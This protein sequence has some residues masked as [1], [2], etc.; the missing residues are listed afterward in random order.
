MTVNDYYI[1]SGFSFRSVYVFSINS[2][3]L[4][5]FPLIFYLAEAS[6]STFL[7][8]YTLA[9][10]LL[11]VQLSKNITKCFLFVIVHIFSTHFAINQFYLHNLKT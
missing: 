5:G 1:L 2:L 9:W 6:F 3:I 4:S 10:M 7:W 11:R 8:L